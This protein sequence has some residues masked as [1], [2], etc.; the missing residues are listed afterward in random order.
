MAIDAS[1]PLRALGSQQNDPMESYGKMMALRNMQMQQD[2]AQRQIDDDR[3]LADIYA[4]AI[5]PST[6][7]INHGAVLSGMARLGQGSKIG[8]Y[9]K[10]VAEAQKAEAEIG[11][12]G[13]DTGLSQAKSKEIDFNM[14]QKRIGTTNNALAS[15]LQKP[16][17]NHDDVIRT[18]NGLV[19]M[20]IATPEEGAAAVR[21]LPGN[22]QAL[23][24]AILQKALQGM[25]AEKQ[26]N[27][28]MPKNE[29]VDL[30]GTRQVVDMNPMSNPN[31]TGTVF[32]KT[33]TPDAI[34]ASNTSRANNAA[35]VS[36]TIRGQNMTDAR[37]RETLGF[38]REKFTA[39]DKPL[40]E[41]QG[42]STGFASRAKA[43]S[44]IVDRVGD[45]G[46][47]QPGMIKRAG[48]AVPLIGNGLGTILNATQ[49]K[50]QQQVEQAQRDFINAVLRQ[51]SGA[52][53]GLDEFDN[54]K[55]QYFP[56]PGDSAEVIEQKRSNRATQIRALEISA[57]PG[58][59]Q[60]NS[61]QPA[62]SGPRIGTVQDGYLF[63]GGDPANPA[64]W[65]KVK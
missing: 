34:L 44:D 42:K 30:G 8:A 53:I 43:A 57:G 3:A 32:K 4:K 20:G 13:A 21:S 11:K 40:T 17:L 48:E 24:Q 10:Q 58:M 51:E 49:S 63:N 31:A 45:S 26:L 6:G 2:T 55:K 29:A 59:K 50:E 62:P 19:D 60:L 39:A 27:M 64:N 47:V 35:T 16:D 41:F 52:A 28:M 15:L 12:I 14:L 36:A 7:K 18:L 38:E 61:K 46:K 54:A 56:Q 65:K 1:I 9:Q 33:E 25:D 5:D 23:R 37:A 22:P